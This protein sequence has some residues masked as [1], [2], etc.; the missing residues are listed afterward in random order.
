MNDKKTLLDSYHYLAN[1][2][3]EMYKQATED[4]TKQEYKRQLVKAQEDI[5]NLMHQC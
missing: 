5:S 2:Y 1:H 4:R 3:K